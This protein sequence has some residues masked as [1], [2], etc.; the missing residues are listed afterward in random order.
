[1]SNFL[2]SPEL[3][4]RILEYLGCEKEAPSIRYLNQ[5]IQ[6]YICHVPWESVSRIVKRHT[7]AD[8]TRCPRWPEEFWHEALSFGTG[9]TC[10]E[11]N[12]AFYTLLAT[13]GFSS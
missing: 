2:L 3:T 7:T 11:C 9:G 5:L 4:T 8:T 10:F 13:L 1:M 6:A 12:L